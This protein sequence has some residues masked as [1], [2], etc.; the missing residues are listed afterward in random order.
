MD[1]NPYR[2]SSPPSSS[3]RTTPSSSVRTFGPQV[4]PAYQN[5][6]AGFHRLAE[7]PQMSNRPYPLLQANGE[8]LPPIYQP[9]AGYA[10]GGG[11]TNTPYIDSF[12]ESTGTVPY[13]GSLSH[14]HTAGSTKTRLSAVDDMEETA[15]ESNTKEQN[16]V[17]TKRPRRTLVESK[18]ESN[19]SKKKQELEAKYGAGN[20]TK[21]NKVRGN[22][23][24]NGNQM[25]WYD[26]KA[27]IYLPCVYHDDI[28]EDLIHIA[29]NLYPE[30]DVPPAKG[31]DP[32]DITS[33]CS[34]LGQ[35]NWSVATDE[36]LAK[37][38]DADGV[39]VML[40]SEKPQ[41]REP[42]LPPVWGHRG[43][44]VLDQESHPILNWSQ[45]P[46]TLSSKLEGWRLEALRRTIPGLEISHLRA[47]M[48]KNV[49]ATKDKV[50]P[51]YGLSTLRHRASRFRDEH[52]I[53]A[54]D[55]RQGT[56]EK[57][58]KYSESQS[59]SRVS[60]PAVWSQSETT[61]PSPR[62]GTRPLTHPST[63]LTQSFTPAVSEDL[64]RPSTAGPQSFSMTEE[65]FAA[66]LTQG[67]RH[68]D[69]ETYP[70]P[71]ATFSESG[72][73]LSA[74][75]Y[76]MQGSMEDAPAEEVDQLSHDTDFDFSS[77]NFEEMARELGDDIGGFGA[78]F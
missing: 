42:V 67:L 62:P 28:R 9:P 14:S 49:T 40:L 15:G 23:I 43:L 39:P 64:T 57:K 13:H 36:D 50:K 70:S 53:G 68:L 55:E 69:S 51:V 77:N 71:P 22:V 17:R 66:Q 10:F 12:S 8:A 54:W 34:A 6:Q 31:L 33:N 41:R 32:F 27:Q 38:H 26:N 3:V 44:V 61:T 19:M 45:L 2:P 4:Q 75:Y 60:I 5:Q 11:S 16:Q 1:R 73:P 76:Q 78:Y 20:V 21:D 52:E 37:I 47:R 30:Y 24:M 18:G 65:Q 25:L 59:T 46:H 48:P 56:V 35:N 58:K 74:P 29:T 72:P 63:L 7:Y